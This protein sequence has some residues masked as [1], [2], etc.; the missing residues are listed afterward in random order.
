[1]EKLKGEIFNVPQMQQWM[2]DTDIIN[3]KTVLE[4]GSCKRFLL[5]VENLLNKKKLPN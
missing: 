1:M 4:S 3:F 2:K 5:I